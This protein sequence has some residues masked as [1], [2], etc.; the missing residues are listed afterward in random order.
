MTMTPKRGIAIAATT[1]ALCGLGVT[2]APMAFA[3]DAGESRARASGVNETVDKLKAELPFDLPQG[4]TVGFDINKLRG[5]SQPILTLLRDGGDEVSRLLNVNLDSGAISSILD[6]L[7]DAADNGSS[8]PRESSDRESILDRLGLGSHGKDGNSES[9][10]GGSKFDPTNLPGFVKKNPDG[11]MTADTTGVKP[12]EYK[13]EG[14]LTTPDGGKQDVSLSFNVSK[15]SGGTGNGGTGSGNNGNGNGDGT[16]DN[17]GGNTG[18]NTGDNT[19]GDNT[20]GNTG[21][22][23]AG[24][25]ASNGNTEGGGTSNGGSSD[26][27]SDN[28]KSDGQ[29]QG[30]VTYPDTEVAVGESKEVKPDKAPKNVTFMN[31]MPDE[32]WV[33]VSRDGTVTLSPESGMS[34]GDKTVT[35]AYVANDDVKKVLQGDDSVIKTTDFTAH[36]TKKDS[37]ADTT[38]RDPKSGSNSGSMHNASNSPG[39]GTNSSSG[40]GGDSVKPGGAGASPQNRGA[41]ENFGGNT[42]PAA[43]TVHDTSAGQAGNQAQAQP[44]PQAQSGEEA[45]PVTGVNARS[46]GIAAVFAL[47]MIAAGAVMIRRFARSV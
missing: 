46:M 2:S 26:S 43:G 4:T 14:T 21:G 45:L 24:G 37:P 1:V 44:Q 47:G 38:E 39:D 23:N 31:G 34:E 40:T 28:G 13:I 7:R 16:G 15:P 12:G 25:N 6:G 8:S 9:G 41:A 17:A 32:K 10:G 29:A 27:S 5:D 19:A 36:V 11:T 33:K 42:G 30:D 18:G 22:D 20:G 35:V 3:Q